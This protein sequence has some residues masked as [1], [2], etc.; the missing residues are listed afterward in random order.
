MHGATQ[1][2]DVS[3]AKGGFR[4]VLSGEPTSAPTNF[5]VDTNSSRIEV[6]E[7]FTLHVTL[8]GATLMLNAGSVG[9]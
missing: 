3:T 8:W 4:D 2:Q 5:T 7:A 9:C 6:P 1:T